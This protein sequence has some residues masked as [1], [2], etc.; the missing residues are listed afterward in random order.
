MTADDLDAL[1]AATTIDQ[2]VHGLRAAEAVAVGR[3]ASAPPEER[4][5]VALW[6]AAC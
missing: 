4:P 2:A 3:L 1:L 5:R 6:R